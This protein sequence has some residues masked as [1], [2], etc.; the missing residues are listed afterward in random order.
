MP[1]RTKT[2]QRSSRAK[3][4][5]QSVTIPAPLVPQVRRIAK[6]RNLTMSRALVSLA[7]RGIQADLEAKE[8]LKTAYNRFMDEKDSVR[9]NEVGKDLIRAIFGTDAIAQDPVR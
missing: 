8:K 3:P 9:K 1:V 4:V 7:E 6:E 2:P 5:R